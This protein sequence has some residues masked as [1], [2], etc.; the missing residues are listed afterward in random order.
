MQMNTHTEARPDE[1]SVVIIDGKIVDAAWT[2]STANEDGGFNNEVS[3]AGN[4]SIPANRE[5]VIRL[6]MKC[7]YPRP[8]RECA[9]IRRPADDAERIEHE[10]F[11]AKVEAYADSLGLN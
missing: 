5:E 7:R 11:F 8:D 10:E 3:N 2:V 6:L 4:V 1:L 9:I